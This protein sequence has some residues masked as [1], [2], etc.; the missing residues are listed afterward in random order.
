MILFGGD[1]IFHVSTH[2]T[3]PHILPITKA[4]GYHLPI[5]DMSTLFI[6]GTSGRINCHVSPLPLPNVTEKFTISG[7]KIL[8]IAP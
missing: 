7:N 5:E 3:K 1:Y 2:L 4:G 6:A 8:K